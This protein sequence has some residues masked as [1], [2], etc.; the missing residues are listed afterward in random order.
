M[1]SPL[2]IISALLLASSGVFAQ[3]YTIN[4]FAGGS[5]P[6]NNPSAQSVALGGLGSVASDSGGN[7]YFISSDSVFMNSGGALVRVAGNSRIGFSGDG[8]PA[9][10]AQL[11][12]PGGIALD[13][14]GN[15][16]I[17]DSGNNRIRKVTPISGTSGGV[18][19]TIAGINTAG[20][21]G[22]T[23]AAASAALNNPQGLALDSSGNL[24]I[25]DSGNHV[26]RKITNGVITTVVGNG[27]QGVTGDGGPAIVARLNA[28]MGVAVDGFL[29]IYVADTGNHRIREVP[30]TGN[31]VQSGTISTIAGNGI[32]G[33]S[34]DNGS[35]QSA[36]LNSPAGVAVDPAGN[37]YVLD[38]NNLR[39]RKIAAFI[40]STV[41]GS[42]IIQKP[43]GVAVDPNSN[44]YVTDSNQGQVLR[45]SAPV[46]STSNITTIAGNGSRY[47][48]GDGGPATAAQLAQPQGLAVDINGIYI[49]D[50][51]EARVRKVNSSAIISLLAGTSGLGAAG[52]AEDGAGNF[53]V[54][55]AVGNQVLKIDSNGN[56]T[57]IAGSGIAGF[58]GDGGPAATAQL[59]QPNGVAVD[60]GG[61][62]IY[63]A[64]TGNNR[65]RKVF[66]SN[67]TGIITTLAGNGN[68]AFGGEN[69]PSTLSVLNQPADVAV[70]NSGN[71]YIADTGNNRVRL[72]STAGI[73]TTVAGNGT[74]TFSGDGGPANAA[75]IVSPHGVAVDSKG[76][77]YVPDFSGRVRKVSSGIIITIAGNGT[78]G[79]SGDGGAAISAQLGMPWGV[80]VD[81]SGDVYVSDVGELAVRVLTPLSVA[82][83]AIV[84]TSL[85]SGTVGTPY[86]QA[87]VATGGTPPYTWTITSGMLPTGLTFSPAGSITGTPTVSGSF[88]MQV[89]VT[90]S[91]LVTSTPVIISIS[92]APS[93]PGGLS[94]TTPPV[95]IP[96]AIG[97]AYSQL[98][99]ATLGNPPYNWTLTSG[100]LPSGLSL[101]PSGLISGTPNLA[102]TSNFTVR[103]NDISGAV[104][105]QNFS[106]TIISVGTLNR[107]GVL[108]HIAVGGPWTTRAY[109]T[110]ISTAPVAVNLQ[111]HDDSGNNLTIPITVTQ[112]GTA[113]PIVTSSFNGVM[114]PNTTLVID[115]GSAIPNTLT[116]WID[117]LSSGPANSLAGFAIFRQLSNGSASEGTTPL[118][119]QF[120]SKMDVPFDNTGGFVTAVA[121]ANISPSPATI[122]ATVLDVNGNLLGTYSVPLGANGHTSFLF[123]SQ[124]A[125]TTN[126]QGIVQFINSA[127]GNV[128][129]VGLRASTT[130][131]TFTSVP[132]ILP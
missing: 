73:I 3:Q 16:Y 127:G 117:V 91:F 53:Y 8:G 115:S 21:T 32:P 11:N 93:A 57:L 99:S 7:I 130:T 24:Y 4:T 128:A 55:D 42:P 100:A 6:P 129:G 112:Q 116:G 82:V 54:A 43:A 107:T 66:F 9:L 76:S 65:I 49:A 77:L 94:I 64:D 10:Q 69:V 15:L 72:I 19:T 125:V 47:N 60:S 31:P 35:A 67:G 110:N 86:A 52:I 27:Q 71:I 87:L 89:Q 132:V 44:L 88:L 90:D 109:L 124:F 79:Y 56:K 95:L 2:G 68:A 105:N 80:T 122:T 126:Q 96:G 85:A 120:E 12:N 119:T 114:N 40:I 37:I 25:A 5:P 123:P 30:Q 103:V 45:Y 102:G 78:P 41:A 97:V 118:Q 39:V 75:G 29:N 104:S 62:N 108:G 70:D 17:A 84:S 61:N 63:I 33:F 13:S 83:P 36:Q 113:Q 111:F 20:Y 74:A 58:F 38:S 22:D 51:G 26:I 106:L 98:L 92:I 28:P 81:G 18:I 101:S 34:G 1:R 121:V 59:N 131:G 46:S 48:L 23:G 14:A 50:R